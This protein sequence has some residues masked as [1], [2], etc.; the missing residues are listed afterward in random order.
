MQRSLYHTVV[1][2]QSKY[3]RDG[4]GPRFRRCGSMSE[5]RTSSGQSSPLIATEWLQRCLDDPRITVGKV[6]TASGHQAHTLAIALQPEAIAVVFDLVE[7]IRAGRD[8]GR[9]GGDAELKGLKHGPKIV[10]A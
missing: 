10:A 8:A 4:H 6:V 9:S 3:L 5:S 1:A 2:H 7:P